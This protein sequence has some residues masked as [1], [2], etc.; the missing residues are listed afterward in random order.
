MYDISLSD[1]SKNVN[2]LN[3]DLEDIEI[4]SK[5]SDKN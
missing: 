2:K 4:G 3:K 1:I 5:N